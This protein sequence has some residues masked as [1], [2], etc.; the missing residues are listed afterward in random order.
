MESMTSKKEQVLWLIA[1]AAAVVAGIYFRFLGIGTW[2]FAY[3]EYYIFQATQFVRDSGLPAFPCG[4]YY[5]RGLLLQYLAAPFLSLDLPPEG[6]IRSITVLSN[7]LLLPA[8]YLLGNRIGGTRLAAGNRI[9][10]TRLAAVVTIVMCLSTWEIEMARFARMYA[11]FQTLFLWYCYHAYRLVEDQDWNRWKWLMLFSV[12][13]PLVWEGGISLAVLNILVLMIVRE[14]FRWVRG[15]SAIS[16]LI[17]GRVFQS[18]NFRH[19]G[20]QPQLTDTESVTSAIGGVVRLRE[21]PIFILVA[22]YQ[23]GWLS[24][25]LPW[26]QLY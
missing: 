8:V 5:A 11:P 10:G 12:L 25:Y 23:H 14:D 26:L 4:G 20:S 24:P 7:L 21:S 15:I 2:P 13:G 19:L 6:V 18:I 9:G 17:L 1:V 16:V 3:D 22:H